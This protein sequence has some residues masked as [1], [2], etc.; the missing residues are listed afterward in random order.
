MVGDTEQ[1]EDEHQDHASQGKVD[2][3]APSPGDVRGEGAADQRADHRCDP[4]H[5]TKETLVLG[6]FGQRNSV[7]NNDELMHHCVSKIDEKGEAAQRRKN[8]GRKLVIAEEKGKRTTP[9]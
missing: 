4:I 5:G 9:D 8:G 7:D 1:E 2:V 3:K 6:P